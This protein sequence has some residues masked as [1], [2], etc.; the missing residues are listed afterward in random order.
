MEAKMAN[1]IVLQ[2]RVDPELK[3]EADELFA[4][5]GLDTPSAVRFFLKQS[6]LKQGLPFSG[7]NSSAKARTG[8]SELPKVTDSS[9]SFAG[10]DDPIYIEGGWKW[11]REDAHERG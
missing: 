11:D 7:D 2:V 3:R 4:G 8:F 6:V 10:I 5:I 9:K 1:T